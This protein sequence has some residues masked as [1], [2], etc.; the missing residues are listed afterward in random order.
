VAETPAERFHRLTGYTAGRHWLVPAADPAVRQD[1]L[2]MVE[3]QQPPD[4]KSY[5]PGLPR[6]TLPADLE[7]GW[8]GGARGAPGAAAVP[9]LTLQQLA[10]LLHWS[11]GVTR[12][13]TA[14]SGQPAWYRAAPSAG[15]RQPIEVYLNVTSVAGLPDG[16]WHYGPHQHLLTR[17]GRPVAATTLLILTGVPW[18]T[19]WKYSER[20]YR[21]LWW[22]AG[23][24]L[25]H[26]EWLGRACGVPVS[27][28]LA[29]PDQAVADAVGADGDAERPLVVAELGTPAGPWPPQAAAERG[30]L[31]PPGP[32]FPL[33]TEVHEAGRLTEWPA[34]ASQRARAPSPGGNARLATD[35]VARR[36]VTRRFRR[37]PIDQR[38]ITAALISASQP[39][40][41][42]AGPEPVAVQ[43]LVH[44]DVTGHRPG[45]YEL[46][47]GMLQQIRSGD[48]RSDATASCLGQPAAGRC[49]CLFLVA[50]DLHNRLVVAGQR[51]YRALQLHA[52]LTA[53]RLQLVA[54]A[55]GLGSAPLTVLDELA[56]RFVPRGMVPLIAVAV[57]WPRHRPPPGGPPRAPTLLPQVSGRRVGDPGQPGGTGAGTRAAAASQVAEGVPDEQ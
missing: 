56:V 22:D 29:F 25:A 14:R 38:A 24:I 16:M 49:A 57:G 40:S 23:A 5:P 41:W 32:S 30:D 53:G 21:H 44:A 2:P 51:G 43:L 48:L 35:V 36:A 33:V 45:C 39:V 1:F 9:V 34:A 12:Y 37:G 54:T 42:D 50:S 6:V 31:G 20:G 4:R 19:E 28:R 46:H 52:G 27:F 17:V 8:P 3:S 26:V 10:W 13:R 15:N 47:G 55:A 11:A 18:R 7:P